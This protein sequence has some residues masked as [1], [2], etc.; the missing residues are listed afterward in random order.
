M[1]QVVRDL[2][3]SALQGVLEGALEDPSIDRESFRQAVRELAVDAMRA[4]LRAA[5]DEAARSLTPAMRSSVVET[6]S[7]PEVREAVSATVSGATRAAVI[8]S[9]DLM[10][11]LHEH[12]AEPQLFARLRRWLTG[13]VVGAFALGAGSSALLAWTLGVHVRAKRIRDMAKSPLK[14]VTDTSRREPAT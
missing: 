1:Q 9:F 7:A 6:L 12:D 10:K 5:T 11:E 3:R 2:S 4:S 14:T 8:S 13:V